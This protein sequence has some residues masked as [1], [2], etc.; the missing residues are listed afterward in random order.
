MSAVASRSVATGGETNEPVRAS[1]VRQQCGSAAPI[2]AEVEMQAQRRLA[3]FLHA[4]LRSAGTAAKNSGATVEDV[5][6]DLTERLDMIQRLN[7]A[8]WRQQPPRKSH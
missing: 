3:E 8:G 5:T 1:A 4:E 7:A 2:D 6:D